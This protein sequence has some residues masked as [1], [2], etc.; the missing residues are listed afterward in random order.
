MTKMA[1]NVQRNVTAEDAQAQHG[2]TLGLVAFLFGTADLETLPGVVLVELLGEFGVGVAAARQ[3]LARMRAEGKLT[4]VRKGRGVAYRL[5]G[6]Y[7]ATFH[8]LRGEDG[9][10]WDGSFHAVLYHVPES[11]RAYRDRLRRRATVV[12]YGHLQHGVLIAPHDRAGELG[13]ALTDRPATAQVLLG[14]LAMEPDVAAAAAATAWSL[15]EIGEILHRHLETL[16]AALAEPGDPPPTVDTLRRLGE[17][18]NS[19]AVDLLRDPD[20]PTQL[21]PPGWP[22]APLRVA[23]GEVIERYQPPAAQYMLERIAATER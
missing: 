10:G 17:L 11:E 15:D 7:R 2:A 18:I 3:Q 6:T 16:R 23:M 14:R 9:P 1:T 12:G 22:G 13:P 20:L 21:C 8:R 5:A 19:A 4:S